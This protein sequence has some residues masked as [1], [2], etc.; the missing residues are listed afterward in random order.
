ML[1]QLKITAFNSKSVDFNTALPL[2]SL[3]LC[4]FKAEIV[5]NSEFNSKSVTLFASNIDL[6]FFKITTFVSSVQ[7]HFK[8]NRIGTSDL[9]F[10][11]LTQDQPNH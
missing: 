4:H 11:L 10:S 3:K 1:I 9:P 8:I 7:C 2:V 6:N 5:G